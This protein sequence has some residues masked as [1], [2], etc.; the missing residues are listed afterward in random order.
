MSIRLRFPIAAK[1][2]VWL[3][4]NL[5]LLAGGGWLFF[6]AQF[7]DGFDS[8]LATAAAPRVE[9]LADT[10]V[11]AIRSTKETQW[12]ETLAS[13]GAAHRVGIAIYHNNGRWV[14][15]P[16]FDLPSTVL[17]ELE[18]P[19]EPGGPR[20]PNPPRADGP[21]HSGPEGGPD[22]RPLGGPPF[23]RPDGPPGRP[24]RR[25]F[26]PARL[27]VANPAEWPKFLLSTTQ[28]T[29]YWIGIR[30]PIREDFR[31]EPLSLVI[32]CDSLGA[33]GLLLETRP[34]LLAGIGAV[35][36]SILFW[37]PFAFGLTRHLRRVTAAT[38]SIARGDFEIRLPTRGGDE[39]G[40]LAL[41]VNTM[42]SQLDA[43]VRGQKRFLGDIAHELC[44]PI[45]RMQ[46]ALAI[47]E[48]RASDEKQAHYVATLREELDD[49]SHLVDEL[50]NF[51]RATAQREIKMQAV[52]ID[53]LVAET[54]AREAPHAEVQCDVPA[55]LVAQAEP[56][57]LARALGNVVRNAVR[58]AGG[59]GPIII[60]AAPAGDRIN[61]VVADNG[62]GVPV[63]SLPR[64]FDAF[65]RPDTART[66]GTGGTGLGLAIVKTCIE[67][68]RGTVAARLGEPH[69]LEVC[70]TLP[71]AA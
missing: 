14:A 33:G 55:G 22:D 26:P 37:L 61:L 35:L 58:Y 24:P 43:L 47:V 8:F 15:G 65:Y 31:Q 19:T 56:K 38:G 59:A 69:G 70:F 18:K 41:S 67:A 40:E 39:L 49:I 1:M 32:R 28:P 21:P 20:R 68:C 57:L 34:F 13:L 4:L 23:A 54:I 71:A 51:S 25:D 27:S 11:R 60:S 3:M 30:A 62:P 42:A 29:A 45:A 5:A 36:V 52:S 10:V 66:H 64:L 50:L 63:D 48:Q 46:A 2:A 16:R 53:R 17:E 12:T 44:S 6:S 7:R 9:S